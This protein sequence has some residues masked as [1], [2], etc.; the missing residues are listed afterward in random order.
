[1]L[2]SRILREFQCGLFILAPECATE[3]ERGLR[4]LG[5]LSGLVRQCGGGG[6]D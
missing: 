3:V 2:T 6:E 1:M 5:F 4:I